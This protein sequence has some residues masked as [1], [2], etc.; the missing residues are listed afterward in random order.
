MFQGV[1]ILNGE[2]VQ[3]GC[4]EE[5]Y[6]DRRWCRQHCNEL[7]T[8]WWAAHPKQRKEHQLKKSAARRKRYAEDPEYRQ[9]INDQEVANKYKITVD[10]L[11]E[12]LAG[13]C[14]A[15][16]S[17]DDLH[18]DHDHSCCPRGVKTCGKCTRGILCRGCNQA[19][20]CLNE[21][22]KRVKLLGDYIDRFCSGDLEW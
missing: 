10:Q 4:T 9:K 11:R 18:I 21:D 1:V 13:G 16:G 22:P 15:C 7:N 19:L 17:F 6:K 2:C 5:R 14:A 20:G 3:L 12:M 8:A